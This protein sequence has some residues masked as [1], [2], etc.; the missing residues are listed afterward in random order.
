MIPSVLHSLS[1]VFESL[2]TLELS[3][4][5][6]SMQPQ[7]RFWQSSFAAFLGLCLNVSKLDAQF[8]TQEDENG[9]SHYGSD[10][11]LE[12]LATWPTFP[13]LTRL[14][15]SVIEVKPHHLL[16]FLERHQETLKHLVLDSPWFGVEPGGWRIVL[17][18]LAVRFNLDRLQFSVYEQGDEFDLVH[19]DGL[20][21]IEAIDK[22]LE[23]GLVKPRP[24]VSPVPSDASDHEVDSY[25]EDDSYQGYPALRA[26]YDDEDDF[27]FPFSDEPSYYFQW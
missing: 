25:E 24:L 27:W 16:E 4:K 26:M 22:A 18:G 12:S 7:R 19:A 17:E 23:T 10:P 11:I 14:C 20:K 21:I 13:N 8:E 1:S 15:L 5:I 9:G 2:A 3:V 6:P